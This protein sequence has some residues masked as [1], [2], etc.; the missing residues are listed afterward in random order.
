MAVWTAWKVSDRRARLLV[1]MS[2]VCLVL[3]LG[4]DGLLLTWLHGLVPQLSF[5]RFPIKFV[6]LVIFAIPLLAAFAVAQIRKESERRP[7][8]RSLIVTSAA[9]LACMGAIVWCA[10][11]YPLA[12]NDWTAT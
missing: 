3:A 12:G 4:E 11:A 9:I 10:H 6:V 5:M 7:I 8:D 2:A 1:A